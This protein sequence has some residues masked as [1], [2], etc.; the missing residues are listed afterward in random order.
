MPAQ[1][2]FSQ[3]PKSI[4]DG[5]EGS[6][7]LQIEV[8]AETRSKLSSLYTELIRMARSC[9][10]KLTVEVSFRTASAHNGGQDVAGNRKRMGRSTSSKG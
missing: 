7:M 4:Q 9:D 8:N 10:S 3:S 5:G 6:R 1:E 2:G